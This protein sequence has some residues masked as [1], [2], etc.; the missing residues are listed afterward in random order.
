MGVLTITAIV[1]AAI[2][3]AGLLNLPLFGVGFYSFFGFAAILHYVLTRPTITPSVIL[4]AI[5]CYLL[6]GSVFSWVY[7]FGAGVNPDIFTPPID[8]SQGPQ[9]IGSSVS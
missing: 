5:C 2:D 4:G 3:R 9:G 6:L 1:G 7:G 8:T